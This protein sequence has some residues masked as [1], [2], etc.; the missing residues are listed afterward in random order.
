M[1]CILCESRK[2]KRY[3][4]A[5]RTEICPV[6]CGEK[7]GVEINCPD[8]CKYLIEGHRYQLQKLTQQ[9]IKKDGVQTYIRRAE[10]YRKNPELFASIELAI[11][12]S[13]N[14]NTRLNDSDLYAALEI[15]SKTLQ[16]ESK[17]L[18][19]KHRSD[20]VIVNELADSID[21][22]INNLRQNQ[23][24]G[25]SITT[26]YAQDVIEDFYNEVKFYIEKDDDKKAYLSHLS[27]FHKDEAKPE[28]KQSGIII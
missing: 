22:E 4:P 13:F 27:R 20:D 3:C 11:V 28:Q 26:G 21:G 12:D 25:N 1:R 17:G 18:I 14:S 23:D 5:K 9:R 2:A 10:L 16:S 24:L 7:R 19:Y 6:C 15:I 8:D